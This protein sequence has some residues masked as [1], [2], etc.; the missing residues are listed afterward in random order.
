MLNCMPKELEEVVQKRVKPIVEKAVHKHLGLHIREIE[1]DISDRLQKPLFEFD[2]DVSVP[3]KEA[4]RRFKRAFLSRVLEVNMGNI[5]EAAKAAGIERES[6]HRL[7]RELKISVERTRI[8][9]QY[10]HDAVKGIIEST[11]ENYKGA[12][13]EQRFKGLYREV[14]NLTDEIAGELPAIDWSFDRA[15]KEFERRYFAKALEKYGSIAE[16]ARAV[17][18]RPE[19]LSRKLK[20]LG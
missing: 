20:Q 18:I 8:P 15:E 1:D 4:K 10:K 7:I 19:T 13:A 14:P 6:L 9:E 3:F 2:V 5:S 16:A 12:F 17:G 11:L